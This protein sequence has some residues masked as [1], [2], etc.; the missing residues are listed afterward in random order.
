MSRT[1]EKHDL[2]WKQTD[3]DI[4]PYMTVVRQAGPRVSVFPDAS[5]DSFHQTLS[6]QQ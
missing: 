2:S 3:L 6:V 4:V 5:S 1:Q